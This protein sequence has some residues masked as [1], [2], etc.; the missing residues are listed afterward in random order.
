MQAVLQDIGGEYSY[1]CCYCCLQNAPQAVLCNILTCIEGNAAITVTT[2]AGLMNYY[3]CIALPE[4]GNTRR[5][6][7][8]M[9]VDM[10]SLRTNTLSQLVCWQTSNTGRAE[11]A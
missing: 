6:L 1:E 11:Q 2:A 9:P 8:H 10:V 3:Y 4:H 7:T 5:S